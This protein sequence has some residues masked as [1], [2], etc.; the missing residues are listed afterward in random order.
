ML[1]MNIFSFISPLINDISGMENMLRLLI[2]H[3]KR[4]AWLLVLIAL[5]FMK[6]G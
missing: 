3:W 1:E 2:R 6:L 4:V 5:R